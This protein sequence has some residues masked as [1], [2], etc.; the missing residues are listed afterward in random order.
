MRGRR[1]D[2]KKRKEGGRRGEEKE[3]KEGGRRGE[4][5]IIDYIRVV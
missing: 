2:E 3:R 4:E 1:G 5:S